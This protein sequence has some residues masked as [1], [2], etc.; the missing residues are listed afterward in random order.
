[1]TDAREYLLARLAEMLAIPCPTGFTD[2]IVH[3]ICNELTALHV[4]FTLTRRGT[5]VATVAGRDSSRA[6][7]VANHLDTIGATVTAI[8][9]NGRLAISPV[10]TWS[11]RFAEGGRVSVFSGQH[12]IRGQVLPVLASGHAFNQQIDTLPVDW[13]QVE[14]RL[15]CPAQDRDGLLAMGIRQ[16]DFVAFDSDPEFDESGYITA[17]H[18]DNK[19][20]AAALLSA[21]RTLKEAAQPPAVD[22]Y[23][24]FT[25]TEEVGTGAGASLDRKV[26]EFVG[27]DI[28]PV[29]AGQ[30]ARETGVTLCAQDTSGPF[31][32]LLLKHLRNLCRYH[33]IAHQVDVFRYYYSD[34][35]SAIVA[36]HDLHHGLITFGT[37]ATHGYER[38]HVT[39]L[40]DIARLLTVYA[41][42]PLLA[43]MSA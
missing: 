43:D 17:R 26:S 39:S 34:A 16:G 1:M 31:D 25:V 15:N 30:N 9:S 28:G 20:G 21:L 40:L 38:T 37:D 41:A 7:A 3:Y 2:E 14:L 33:D 4:P 5:I 42:S 18:L 12:V 22:F 32:R 23:A 24:I 8:K 29:A 35:N 36:G 27:I 13:Q 11:S 6:R 19:A 10:G